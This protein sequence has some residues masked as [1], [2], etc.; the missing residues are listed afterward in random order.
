[1]GKTIDYALVT[2]GINDI[3]PEDIINSQLHD[4][5]YIENYDSDIR[6]IG[7]T[8]VLALL[9]RVRAKCPKAAIFYFG[10]YPPLSYESSESKIREFLKHENDDDFRWF[11][12]EYIYREIDV[13]SVINQAQTRG[14]WF[15]GRWQYWTRQ[16]VA[17][18]N[19]ADV[20][21]RPG[22]VYVPSGFSENNAVYAGL[23]YLWDD[24]QD[25]TQDPAQATRVA[26][27]PRNPH[28]AAMVALARSWSSVTRRPKLPLSKPPSWARCRSRRPCVPT[29][30]ARAI[31]M[32]SSYNWSRKSTGSSM[33][34]SRP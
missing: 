28:Y 32:K 9:Q 24:Y 26:Q 29:A 33:G 20:D 15:H 27:I 5:T 34:E 7:Y 14:L 10:F 30:A 6:K 8:Q 13:D 2:G 11:F 17:A 23:S 3:G 18:A 25:P 12:N 31:S 16:A 19:D 21:G 4:G 22:V 1:M